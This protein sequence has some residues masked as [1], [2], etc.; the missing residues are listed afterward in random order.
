M[1]IPVFAGNIGFGDPGSHYI[2]SRIIV[3]G[4]KVI[5]IVAGDACEI[6]EWIGEIGD[7][8]V[9]VVIQAGNG[10]VFR[11]QW[12]PVLIDDLYM[13]P[14]G[15]H[16][17]IHPFIVGCSTFERLVRDPSLFVGGL[18]IIEGFLGEGV[19]NDR[20]FHDFF[21]RQRV[22]GLHGGEGLVLQEFLDGFI[23]RGKNRE[24]TRS[25]QDIPVS[26]LIYK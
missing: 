13:C 17:V 6:H 14:G 10:S 25:S 26:R 23:R 19:V 5:V 16:V 12:N 21:S 2:E 18:I 7:V 15:I 11:K 24:V 3:V 9:V 22:D 8:L 4:E 1:H 20:I